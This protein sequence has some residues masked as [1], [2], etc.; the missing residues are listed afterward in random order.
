MPRKAAVDDSIYCKPHPLSFAGQADLAPSQWTKPKVS[1][2]NMPSS[3]LHDHGA[4]SHLKYRNQ[5]D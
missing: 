4:P 5:R 3:P 2:S 1:S